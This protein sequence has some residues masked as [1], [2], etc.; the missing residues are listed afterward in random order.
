MKKIQ[1]SDINFS[2]E[3]EG[4][5]WYSNVQNPIYID[6]SRPIA[7]EDFTDM[8]FIVEGYLY[9]NSENGKSIKI[10]FIDGVYQIY[11]VE[12]QGIADEQCSRVE[13]VIKNDKR[14]LKAVQFWEESQDSACDGMPVLK[15]SWIAFEGF[16]SSNSPES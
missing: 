3:Y 12:L 2:L 16:Q 7:K 14:K 10:K 15:P 11:S 5:I 13:F 4:Y 8:P 9:N 1:V 6:S